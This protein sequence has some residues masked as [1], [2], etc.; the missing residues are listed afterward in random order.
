[1]LDA[2]CLLE[3][4]NRGAASSGE[5]GMRAGGAQLH[6]HYDGCFAANMMGKGISSASRCTGEPPPLPPS[7]LLDS[8]PRRRPRRR[9]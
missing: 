2:F 1:M 9:A 6:D 4:S 3:S 8:P 7:E 5:H